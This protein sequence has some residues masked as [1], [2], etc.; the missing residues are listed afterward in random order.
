M[1]H[2]RKNGGFT[3]VELIAVTA[4]LAI[5]AGIALPAY[6][7]YLKRV[8]TA[9]DVAT[10]SAVRT[11]AFAA[12]PERPVERIIVEAEDGVVSA[13][14]V[15][16]SG[17]QNVT[18]FSADEESQVPD[19]AARAFEMYMPSVPDLTYHPDGAVWTPDSGWME[20]SE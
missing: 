13:V 14:K 2:L 10:L 3:L 9:R 6:T 17:G 16:P 15:I 8:E 18:V 20:P 4:I 12:S 5:L 7:G 11:A 19:A 1:T